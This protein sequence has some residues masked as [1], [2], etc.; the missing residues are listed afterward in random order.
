ME[1]A[2]HVFRAVLVLL[3]VVVGVTLGR[4]SLRPKSYGQFGAYRGENV[5]E[6]MRVRT[7]QHGG[8]K[9]CAPCH[10]ERDAKW[11]AGAHQPVSCEVCHGP[12]A[13]HVAD[14]KRSAAMPV[15][16]SFTLCARCHRKILGRP[17]SFPQVAL[18][19]HVRDQGGGGPV[20]GRVCLDCHDPH[21][22][23]L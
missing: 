12:L 3:V 15:D 9:S 11:S 2:R 22:P 19:Q 21:S 17:E 7:P 1:H 14:G 4:G 13:R 10:A 23:K 16:P 8:A 20:Q 5:A 18:D 6:Q